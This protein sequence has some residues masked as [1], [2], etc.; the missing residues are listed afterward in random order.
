MNSAIL[1][2]KSIDYWY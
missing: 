2:N 1:F